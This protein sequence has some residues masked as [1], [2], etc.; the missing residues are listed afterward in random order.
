LI[1]VT[2]INPLTVACPTCSTLLQPTSVKTSNYTLATSDCGGTVQSGTGTTG[3]LTITLP[4]AA[5]F[6]EGCS[7]TVVNGDSWSGGR[8][9][10][11]SGFP[12]G[13]TNGQ[14]ILWPTQAGSVR[15]V[16]GA[17][18]SVL[19][20]GRPKLPSGTVNA[21]ANFSLGSDIAGVTDG[22]ASGASAFKT[23]QSAMFMACQEFDLSAFPQTNYTV[24]V[25]ANVTDTQGVHYACHG[26]MGAQGGAAIYVTGGSNATISVNNVDAF[27]VDTNA[28]VSINGITMQA[29]GNVATA[30]STRPADCLRADY[31]G[32]IFH[33]T[34]TYVVCAGAQIAADQG[35]NVYVFSTYYIN[36]SANNHFYAQNGG[37]ITTGSQTSGFVTAL[38]GANV[39]F[40]SGFAKAGP[41]GTINIPGWTW[42]YN[43]G[44][45]TIV[46]TKAI[47]TG[48]G[49]ISG[50]SGTVACNTTFFPGTVNGAV[51]SPFCS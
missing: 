19:R 21:Y 27:A 4:S 51:A 50:G 39:T 37:V 46:G 15:V 8:G 6:S 23:I 31:G 2:G 26:A 29:T 22:L 7:I 20:P 24:N 16:N 10:S 43:G 40:T 38:V 42:N 1:T 3:L 32:R 28:V 18:V 41:G 34:N 36:S 9:K 48:A 25:A 47:T 14:L 17:W 5:G 11:L 35:G 30:A 44:P 13:F 45:W 33:L 49:S 12:A